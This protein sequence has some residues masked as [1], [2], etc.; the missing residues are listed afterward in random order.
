M[1]VRHF[2]LIPFPY[3]HRSILVLHRL[4]FSPLRSRRMALTESYAHFPWRSRGLFWCLSAAFVRRRLPR[5]QHASLFTSHKPLFRLFLV[6]T[7]NASNLFVC[8]HSPPYP[9]FCAS[10]LAS[11]LREQVLQA[12]IRSNRGL[13]CLERPSCLPVLTM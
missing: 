3:C 10:A 11:G 4:S 2:G 8:H 12:T 9:R 13:S 5:S 7:I 1:A 6:F